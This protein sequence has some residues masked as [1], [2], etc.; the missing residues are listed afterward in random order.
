MY[1]MDG[2]TILII[3][4]SVIF[5]I[6]LIIRK[7]MRRKSEGFE[8]AVAAFKHRVTVVT[9]DNI[10][11]S[12]ITEVKGPVAGESETSSSRR[13]KLKIAE[14][15]AMIVIM[16]EALSLGANAITGY[17]VFTDTYMQLDS[18]KTI[19]KVS[20]SGTAVEIRRIQSEIGGPR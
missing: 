7:E 1:R 19:R 4:L 6:V 5:Q 17:K 15:D 14:L 9:S 16:H 10:P 2:H 13:S 8:R 11:G 20:C 12:E 18:K 3:L